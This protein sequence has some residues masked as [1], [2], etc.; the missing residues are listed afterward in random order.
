MHTVEFKAI[1]PKE[2]YRFSTS[3]LAKN[4]SASSYKNLG[5]GIA[6]NERSR[7]AVARKKYSGAKN[8]YQFREKVVDCDSGNPSN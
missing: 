8:I 5:A 4:S 6:A 1:R 3:I 2:G 7:D